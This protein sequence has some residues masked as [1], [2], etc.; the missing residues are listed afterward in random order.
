MSSLA[1]VPL[2]AGFYGKFLVFA[3]AVN[4]QLWVLV[5]LGVVTVGAGFYY[6][7]R[8]VAAMYWYEPT[9]T[10]PIHVSSLS[11]AVMALLVVCIFVFGVNPSPILS[12]LQGTPAKVAAAH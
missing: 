5:A 6:Y 12:A 8:V 10:A 2:T 9:D 4:A 11:K 1:G 3:H 7:L